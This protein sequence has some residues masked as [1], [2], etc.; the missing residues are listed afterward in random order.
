MYPPELD[1]RLR[2][3]VPI[4]LIC[5]KLSQYGKPRSRTCEVTLIYET[6]CFVDY[7]STWSMDLI[8]NTFYM[9]HTQSP[10]MAIVVRRGRGIADPL[11]V[12][13]AGQNTLWTMSSWP[14]HWCRIPAFWVLWCLGSCLIS[15]QASL[16]GKRELPQL[17]SDE[18]TVLVSGVPDPVN[19]LDPANSASHLSKILIPRA[20]EYSFFLLSIHE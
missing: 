12:L 9:I 8:H 10:W 7:L 13:R 14:P 15:L 18:L 17:S 3:T 2:S 19:K 6:A 20:R 1:I 16:F 4:H 5:R 11:G